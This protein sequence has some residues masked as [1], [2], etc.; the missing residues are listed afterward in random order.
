MRGGG[1]PWGGILGGDR[2]T[3][4][5]LPERARS[6]K[7]LYSVAV[8]DLPTDL[9]STDLPSLPISRRSPRSPPISPRSPRSPARF[10]GRLR[11]NPEGSY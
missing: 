4:P 2:G 3:V 10:G 7:I 5:E 9:P 8:T 11:Q 1:I 6:V